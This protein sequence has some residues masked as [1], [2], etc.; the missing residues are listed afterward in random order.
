M[1]AFWS[2]ETSTVLV[3]VRRLIRDYFESVE[4]LSIRI[5]VPIISTNK[6]RDVVGMGC[7]IQ[8]MDAS[9]RKGMWQDQ[10]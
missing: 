10:L 1:G 7:A 9:Q 2:Q 8:T 5:P 6:F 3:N 4:A